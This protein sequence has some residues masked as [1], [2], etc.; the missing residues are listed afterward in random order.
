VIAGIAGST[1]GVQ[2]FVQFIDEVRRD[3]NL[4]TFQVL[5]KHMDDPGA[6]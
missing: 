6:R 5:A 3:W 4:A 1:L 2:Q